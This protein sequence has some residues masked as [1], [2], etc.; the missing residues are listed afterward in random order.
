M[1]RKLKSNCENISKDRNI[2]MQQIEGKNSELNSCR[3]TIKNLKRDIDAIEKQKNQLG[4]Q[5]KD[6]NQLH[7]DRDEL[8]ALNERLRNK[9]GE[10]SKTYENLKDAND[11]EM[12][13]LNEE[14]KKAKSKICELDSD[15]EEAN[16]IMVR[17]KDEIRKLQEESRNV[18]RLTGELRN[19]QNINK[20]LQRQLNDVAKASELRQTTLDPE[21]EL[22]KHRMREFQRLNSDLEEKLQD[23]NRQEKLLRSEL[24]KEKS[25]SSEDRDGFEIEMQK[26]A[27]ELILADENRRSLETQVKD[28][29]YIAESYKAMIER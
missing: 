14:L 12:V 20:V 18:E 23:C 26:L 6:H 13:T 9:L 16:A 15:N 5:L 19:C 21:L 3:E 11:N 7:K 4:K 25:K 1:N 29:S 27:N 17:L 24:A 2:L 22:I 8:R 10:V 28:L